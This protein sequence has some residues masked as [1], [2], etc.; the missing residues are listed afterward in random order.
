MPRVTSHAPVDV[1]DHDTTM[2]TAER[3]A[4]AFLDAHAAWTT[5]AISPDREKGPVKQGTAGAARGDC[6]RLFAASLRGEC[7][8][9]KLPTAAGARDRA[10]V[11]LR[12]A[13]LTDS[14]APAVTAW[15]SEQLEARTLS[16]ASVRRTLN[17]VLR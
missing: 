3:C 2:A 5:A 14:F 7:R 17:S 9:W 16:A 8:G 15:A 4:G 13:L 1:L 10:G 12:S 11:S 6:L